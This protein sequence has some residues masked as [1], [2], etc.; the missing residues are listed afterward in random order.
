MLGVAGVTPIV[1]PLNPVG[2]QSHEQ[3]LFYYVILLM[4]SAFLHLGWIWILETGGGS[5]AA[6]QV[7]T[8]QGP[9]DAAEA[10]GS[11]SLGSSL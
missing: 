1:W 3:T 2:Q 7:V 11:I 9:C 4:I 8:G 5:K 6:H 10:G